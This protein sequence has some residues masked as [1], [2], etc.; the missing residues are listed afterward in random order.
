MVVDMNALFGDEERFADFVHY[1]A[2]GSRRFGGS[3]DRAG[4]HGTRSPRSVRDRKQCGRP[5]RRRNGS[6]DLQR[7]RHD[8]RSSGRRARRPLVARGV[9]GNSSTPHAVARQ[10]IV[11]VTYGI[12]A[13]RH[14][15]RARD[16]RC[17]LR[18]AVRPSRRHFLDRRG[19]ARPSGDTHGAQPVR[20]EG[21]SCFRQVRRMGRHPVGRQARRTFRP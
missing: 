4:P 7:R 21:N 10:G 19:V 3:R 13:G 2:A 20:R 17:P 12:S 6:R 11:A 1:N 16:A 14:L 8:D 5:C 15:T 9:S 18:P